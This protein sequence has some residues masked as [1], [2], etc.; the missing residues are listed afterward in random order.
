MGITERTFTIL[1]ADDDLEDCLL[2]RE[3]LRENRTYHAL[4]TV[5]DGED[6]LDYLYQRGVYT[7]TAPRPDLILLDLKMPKKDGREALAEI[8]TDAGLRSI[9]IVV[10]TTSTAEDDIDYCYR[11][12]VSS[13]IPKP[14]TFK[15]WLELMHTLTKYWFELVKL[16]TGQ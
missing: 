8:K 15:A 13:Y 11:L 1:M 3:A 4:Q 12:G 7:P 14:V 5:N 9:P 2:V 16:P 10:L 6:L